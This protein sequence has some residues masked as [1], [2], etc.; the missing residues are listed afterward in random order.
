MTDE[1]KNQAW[2]WS[3]SSGVHL[4][5]EIAATKI[6]P[7]MTKRETSFNSS[8]SAEPT[9]MAPQ[10]CQTSDC[11]AWQEREISGDIHCRCGML[12]I[13]DGTLI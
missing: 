10:L 13:A 12:W 4:T 6:C 3:T 5:K 7:I 11:M 2:G 1:D 9:V 8:P